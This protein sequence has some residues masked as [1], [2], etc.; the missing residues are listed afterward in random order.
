MRDAQ[1]RTC[2]R[3]HAPLSW[4][5]A[6]PA[7]NSARSPTSSSCAQLVT[8]QALAARR[9]G[10]LTSIPSRP[11]PRIPVLAGRP[12]RSPT[13]AQLTEAQAAASAAR[14]HPHEAHSSWTT[15]CSQP[16]E[17]RLSGG[18]ASPPSAQHLPYPQVSSPSEPPP[19]VARP[20]Q[21]P[22]RPRPVEVAAN[23]P[24][25]DSSLTVVVSGAQF[26]GQKTEP[27]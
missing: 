8:S 20:L 26:L 25:P 13:L 1:T 21:A 23:R 17:S 16:N 12:A 18:R 9:A 14:P 3:D 4:P 5:A 7:A 6:S 11:P 2:D 27:S 10:P 22:V 24:G 15:P 19:G